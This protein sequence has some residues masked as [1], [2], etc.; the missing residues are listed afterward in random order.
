MLDLVVDQGRPVD[1][2]PVNIMVEL[3]EVIER[4]IPGIYENGSIGNVK[5]SVDDQ[6]VLMEVVAGKHL[7]LINFGAI[8]IIHECTQPVIF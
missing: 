7:K 8:F 2:V 5:G 1:Q 4:E 6:Q 3:G